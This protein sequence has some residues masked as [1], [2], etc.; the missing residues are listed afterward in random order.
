MADK[1]WNHKDSQW[2][3]LIPQWRDAYNLA[4]SKGVDPKLAVTYGAYI[5]STIFESFRY[6]RRPDS[7]LNL[8]R[9]IWNSVERSKHR[10]S[11]GRYAKEY[12]EFGQKCLFK[13]LQI[14]Y[15][16]R[17]THPL[18]FADWLSEQ[19]EPNAAKHADELRIAM[20]NQAS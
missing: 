5:I 11:R 15:H 10:Y 17:F 14:H 8:H 13:W 4:L 3:W 18:I 9:Y 2:D 6:Y 1:I 19:D 20:Q 7:Y 16:A 12:L